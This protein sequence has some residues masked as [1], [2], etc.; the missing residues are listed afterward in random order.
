M[1]TISGA[2]FGA[3]L[4]GASGGITTPK[5]H[6]ILTGNAIRSQAS[7]VSS[8][9]AQGINSID[10][11]LNLRASGVT[12]SPGTAA[13]PTIHYGPDGMA[14]GNLNIQALDEVVITAK[15]TGGT[16]QYSD[17]L[18]K[19]AQQ[20][21]PKLAGKIQLHHIEPKYLGGARNGPLVPLDAAYHQMITNE[22][23]SL[24]GYGNGLPSA[25]ELQNI[26]KQVYSKYPLPP[27]YRF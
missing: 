23:R 13:K 24:W 22:F 4:G 26:M 27:G 11:G 6:N 18:V 9:Q 25:T 20:A 14:S 2:A 7:T 17:N 8:I 10:D 3:V 1:G 12:G 15:A 21:Y 5:R 19:A 16:V